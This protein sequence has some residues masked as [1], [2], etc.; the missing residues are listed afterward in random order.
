MTTF[1]VAFWFMIGK[2]F[3]SRRWIALFHS[4]RFIVPLFFFG[5]CAFFCFTRFAHVSISY[6]EWNEDVQSIH[7]D[8]STQFCEPYFANKFLPR[9]VRSWSHFVSD[10]LLIQI[11]R[12]RLHSFLR[13]SIFISVVRCQ[14]V[15]VRII[16]LKPQS[17]F[18]AIHIFTSFQKYWRSVIDFSCVRASASM[19][20]ICAYFS[21]CGRKRD[22]ALV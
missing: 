2:L 16:T 5:S 13:F 15:H 1:R 8:L 6:I 12:S 22:A 21:S 3:F 20:L 18:N 9:A 11:T 4:S 14:R 17:V 7:V 19:P 10:F